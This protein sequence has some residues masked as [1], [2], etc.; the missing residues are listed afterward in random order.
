MKRTL[1]LLIA[2]SVVALFAS[3][4]VNSVRD[5]DVSADEVLC[6][7]SKNFSDL[8]NP[9]IFDESPYH[10]IYKGENLDFY[11][12]IFSHDGKTV[13]ETYAEPT[14]RIIVRLAGEDIAALT[15]SR[16]TLAAY[17]KYFG[18][19]NNLVSDWHFLVLYENEDYIV[20]LEP[21]IKKNRR[22]IVQN[23]FNREVYYQEFE[24]LGVPLVALPVL[25]IGITNGAELNVVFMFGEEYEERAVVINLENAYT[26][27]E[28]ATAI[29]EYT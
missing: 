2:V 28:T 21:E 8:V 11:I 3:C 5:D 24:V 12:Y 1:F 20:F 15:I 17:T 26:F 22:L 18:L 6:D 29:K 16:G 25:E 9:R 13:Y 14:S 23:H 4:G 27:N 19:T 10:K 7:K